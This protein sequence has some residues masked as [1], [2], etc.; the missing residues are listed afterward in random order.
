MKIVQKGF[1]VVEL[2]VV[3]VVIG[4]LARVTIVAYSGAQER[5]EYGKA[6]SDIKNIY[7]AIIIYKSQTGAYPDATTGHYTNA[8][9]GVKGDYQYFSSCT[10]VPQF[11]QVLSDGKYID[12]MPVGTCQRAGKSYSYAYFTN[13]DRSEYKLLRTTSS[14]SLPSVELSGNPL[15]DPVRPQQAWGYWSDGGASF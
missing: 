4:I 14:A 6:Q 7:D 12:T 1:T 8:A 5:A 3:V 2:I 10:V 15:I 11:I 9:T 13:A